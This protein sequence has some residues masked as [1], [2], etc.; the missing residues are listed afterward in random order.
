MC[1]TRHYLHLPSTQE[2][3]E[4]LDVH[5]FQTFQ[6]QAIWV[7]RKSVPMRHSWLSK[8]PYTIHHGFW[9]PSPDVLHLRWTLKV[10]GEARCLFWAPLAHQSQRF[11]ASQDN[12]ILKSF[13]NLRM[14]AVTT[15][16]LRAKRKYDKR[17][18]LGIFQKSVFQIRWLWELDCVRFEYLP[19]FQTWRWYVYVHSACFDSHTKT[20][21]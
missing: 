8:E 3:P 7:Q 17:W 4:S 6:Y 10:P 9:L 11:T 1:T 2:T 21:S 13:R 16:K 19:N 18:G 14:R 15:T 20:K 12:P 5:W